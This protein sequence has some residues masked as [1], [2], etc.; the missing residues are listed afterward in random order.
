MS[1]Q[2]TIERDPAS[3]ADKPQG[4]RFPISP[5]GWVG[6]GAALLGIAY[7]VLPDGASEP[8][9]DRK[10]PPEAR[11]EVPQSMVN[12]Y[13]VS[14]PT[15]REKPAPAAGEEAAAPTRA[16]IEEMKAPAATKEEK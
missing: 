7:F 15:A 4:R 16:K 8:A 10:P 6:I 1:E 9:P 12:R 3:G 13:E 2:P 11:I 5:V 14:G